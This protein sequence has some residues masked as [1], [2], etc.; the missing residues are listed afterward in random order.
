M[1]TIDPRPIPGA[2]QRQVRRLAAALLLAALSC[3]APGSPLKSDESVLLPAQT[4]R[5]DPDLT[6]RVRVAA[7]VYELERRP[8]M[9]TALARYLDLDRSQLSTAERDLLYARTQ[10]FRI[11][12]ER[13]KALPLVFADSGATVILPATN[14]NGLS[15]A[16]VTLPPLAE[17]PRANRWLSYQVQ[18]RDGDRRRF[19]GRALLLTA[20]GISVVSDIDDTIKDS[21]VLDR[22]ALLLN[23]F[24]RPFRA[25][26]GMAATYQAW[27]A[28]DP[29]VAFHYLSGS[30]Q[31]MQPALDD[32]LAQASFP[33]GTL[34]LRE[35][36]LED[37]LFGHSGGTPAHKREVLEQ[38]RADFPQRRFVLI[39]D[40]GEQDPEI[41]GSFAR[42]HREAVKAIWIREVR[43]E[44]DQSARY[45]RAFADLPTALWNCF[46]DP[47]SLPKRL[48]DSAPP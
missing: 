35:V 26:P 27:T 7:I 46:S 47:A 23:T 11:D 25:V 13:G 2:S 8:G 22:R 21:N 9:T 18:T 20:A 36:D 34:H 16:E 14:P 10:L 41:Y 30:P 39:G 28:P 5:L 29:R 31:Q 19:A 40:S 42:A 32:F 38:L 43:A 17:A 37:E 24:V 12:F 15:R 4:A 33:P 6:L 44:E 3:S 45:A 1:P 48:D